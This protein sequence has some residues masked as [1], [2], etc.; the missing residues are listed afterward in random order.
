MLDAPLYYGWTKRADGGEVTRV[1]D[2]ENEVKPLVEKCMAIGAKFVLVKCGVKGMYWGNADKSGFEKSY[3]PEKVLCTTGAGDT[4]IAAFLAAMLEG[5]EYEE[6]VKLAAAQGACC[7]ESY[8][9]IGGL[10]Q[11]SE[12]K[13]KI[14]KGWPK[15]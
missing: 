12:L 6:C 7:V 1:I 10:R 15:A 8:D 2:I 4:S 13:E 3:K 11:L 9:A 5:A 14:G